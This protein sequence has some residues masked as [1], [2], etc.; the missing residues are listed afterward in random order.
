MNEPVGGDSD[1]DPSFCSGNLV[2]SWL[3]SFVS[4]VGRVG[5][6]GCLLGLELNLASI[7]GQMTG[8][9]AACFL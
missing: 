4:Q 7:V 9:G 6:V 5:R 2:K 8:E 1:T 3:L